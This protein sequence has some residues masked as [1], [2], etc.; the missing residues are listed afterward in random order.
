M[1]AYKIKQQENYKKIKIVAVS[2]D[3]KID[4]KDEFQQAGFDVSLATPIIEH[5]VKDALLNLLG[6][7]LWQSKKLRQ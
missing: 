1:L 2:S 4:N 7:K 5:E 3:V 6:E